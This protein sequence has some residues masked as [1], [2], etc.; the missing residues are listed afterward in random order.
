MFVYVIFL[1]RLLYFV[2]KPPEL[3]FFKMCEK[4]RSGENAPFYTDVF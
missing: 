4:R 1:T 3:S 2:K